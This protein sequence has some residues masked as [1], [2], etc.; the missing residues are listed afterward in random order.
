MA[1]ITQVKSQDPGTFFGCMCSDHRDAPPTIFCN[2]GPPTGECVAY[3]Q[4]AAFSLFPF[5]TNRTRIM[6]TSLLAPNSRSC[7]ASEIDFL[8]MQD[9][10]LNMSAS[11][12]YASMIRVH[13]AFADFVRSFATHSA[14]GLNLPP[15]KRT[16]P[17]STSV[18][19]DCLTASTANVGSIPATRSGNFPDWVQRH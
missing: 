19:H 6:S 9:L 2:H 7:L 4:A 3:P 8:L 14:H 11:C 13:F 18:A 5:S 12:Q 16:G 10:T 1:S 15:M 17:L